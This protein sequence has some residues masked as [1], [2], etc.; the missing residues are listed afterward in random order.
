[1]HDGSDRDAI[2]APRVQL[3]LAC[4]P[5]PTAQGTQAA[6]AAI[7]RAASDDVST[8][9][10]LLTYAHGAPGARGA[11]GAQTDGLRLHRG[12]RGWRLGRGGGLRSGPSLGK[13][14]G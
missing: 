2:G 8:E 5:F 12:A 13:V 9:A 4:M 1:M 11:R 6:V 10:H 14:V 7:V 3:H